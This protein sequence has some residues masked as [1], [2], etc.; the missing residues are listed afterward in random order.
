MQQFIINC[1][2]CMQACK[3]RSL[4]GHFTLRLEAHDHC[5]W[6]PLIGW[7]K[8]RPS[9]LVHFRLGGKGWK[10]TWIPAWQSWMVSRNLSQ[11]HLHKKHRPNANSSNPCQLT[12][13][14]YVRPLDDIRGASQLRGLSPWLV[15]KESG[16]LRPPTTRCW[17]WCCSRSS[18]GARF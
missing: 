5:S 11:A 12:T 18:L 14:R 13:T 15:C 10:P 2:V 16:P 9:P 3:L 6:R 7:T 4:Q 1:R 8:L 17:C